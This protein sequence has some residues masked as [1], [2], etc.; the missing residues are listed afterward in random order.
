VSLL[1]ALALFVLVTYLLRVVAL[2][3]PALVDR[4]DEW[5]EPLT[6]AVLASLVVSGT[7]AV[8]GTLAIDARLVGLGIAAAAAAL[9]APLLV[10]LVA[11]VAGAAVF[12]L[13]M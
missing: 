1:V 7:F 11:A 5:A 3:A 8:N 6:A 9:R 13:V 10:T 2:L 12:R 4:L